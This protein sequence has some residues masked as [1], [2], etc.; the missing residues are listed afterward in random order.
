L[1]M[2]NMQASCTLEGVRLRYYS[3]DMRVLDLPDFQQRRF[4]GDPVRGWTEA[5]VVA[6]ML[7]VL[8]LI[9]LVLGVRVFSM[10]LG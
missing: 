2:G 3:G 5:G 1:P 10:L 4:G 7:S 8:V 6:A 9:P